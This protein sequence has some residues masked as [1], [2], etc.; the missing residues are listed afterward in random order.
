MLYENRLHNETDSRY[1][2]NPTKTF[3]CLEQFISKAAKEFLVA[4][5]E[6]NRLSDYQE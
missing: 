3:K 4:G 1:G 6:M 5:E 2:V